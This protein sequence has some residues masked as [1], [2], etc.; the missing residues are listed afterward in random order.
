L[1]R[2]IVE[3]GGSPRY[4]EFLGIGDTHNAWDAAYTMPELYDWL[5]K[6]RRP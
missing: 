4:T 6:Q 5:A 1:I 2:A 3:A